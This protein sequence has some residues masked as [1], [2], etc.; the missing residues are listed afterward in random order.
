MSLT[1]LQIR[2]AI[3]QYIDDPNAKRWADEPLDVVTQ[4]VYDD[5]YTDILQASPYWNSQ[6][7]QVNTPL[8]V[9]GY[10]DL[11]L[12]A[13]GG[14]LSKRLYKLQQVMA[15]GRQYFSKDP[16]DYLLQAATFT[17]D[18]STVSAIV[19]QRYTYQLLGN[20]LWLHPLGVVITFAE[21]RYSYR[22]SPY[23]GLGDTAVVEFPDG[24]EHALILAASA[25]AMIKGGA[26]DANPM[27]QLAEMA[28]QRMLDMIRRR[29]GIIQPY[30]T[31]TMTEFGGT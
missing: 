9:P 13:D 1:K 31:G 12:V 23:I 2:T 30:T 19:E 7:D 24:T 18:L 3:H 22:P 8:T 15:D 26:E 17:G 10:I 16:R 4:I 28:R 25:H 27:L 14:K 6:Y 21:L 20:Q 5:L 11:R 29:P